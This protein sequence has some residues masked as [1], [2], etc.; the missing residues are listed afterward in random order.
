V[1]EYWHVVGPQKAYDTVTMLNRLD[2]SSLA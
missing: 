1:E 2:V